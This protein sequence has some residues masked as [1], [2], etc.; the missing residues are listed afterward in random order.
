MITMLFI[1]APHLSPDGAAA[2]ARTGVQVKV[3]QD[4][5]VIDLQV[6]VGIHTHF[7]AL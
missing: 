3:K 7:Q 2:L 4:T 1:K 5:W 6:W